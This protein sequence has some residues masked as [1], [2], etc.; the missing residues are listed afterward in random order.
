MS[1]T[2]LEGALLDHSDVVDSGVIGVVIKGEEVP[3]A[4]V[5]RS[6]DVTEQEIM[7]WMET[8]VAK[9]KWLRG[10]VVFVDSIPR[11]QVSGQKI[12]ML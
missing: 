1:P 10:G 5:V 2:E 8:R 9:Y 3:R 11:V 12:A 6:S 4:Y 7:R